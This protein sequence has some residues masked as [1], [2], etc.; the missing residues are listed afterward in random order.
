[1]DTISIK[2]VS[3]KKDLNRFLKMQWNIY[4]DYENWVPPLL[5]DK[6]KLLNKKKNPFFKHADRELFIAEKNG[7]VVGR[8]AAIRNDLHNKEHNDKVG[9]FGFFESI[10]DQEITNKLLDRVK[11]WLKEQG[12]TEMRGPANPSVNDEYGL[13]IDGFDDPPRLLMTYNPRYYIDLLENYGLMKA[14]DL[15]AYKIENEKIHKSEKLKRV[16]DIARKRSG[17]KIR[18]LN[19]KKFNSELEKIKFVFNSAWERNWGFVPLTEEE[20]DTLAKDLKPLFGEIE[21]KTIGFALVM[22]DY[23][24]VFKEMNGRLFPFGFIKLFTKSKKIPW[25]RILILGIVPEYQKRGLDAVFYSEVVRRAQ[26]RNILI[27]EA[28]WILEDNDMMN[29][30]AEV[31]NAYIYKKYR[32]YEMSI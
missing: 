11:T 17:I 14:K 23:N 19:M 29:R 28:S 8:I 3:T 20:I 6:K 13:L 15:Y 2:T 24:F 25:A 5:H 30:A 7:G 16:T 21:G 1:M 4:A 22:P 9:F 10:N 27:G 18:S 32:I 31:M 26:E 12:F